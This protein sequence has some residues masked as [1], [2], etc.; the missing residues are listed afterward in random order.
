MPTFEVRGRD[1]TTGK[2][3]REVVEADD[4]TAAVK[5][6]PELSVTDVKKIGDGQS[7]KPSAGNEPL[8]YEEARANQHETP[9]VDPTFDPFEPEL[10]HVRYGWTTRRLGVIWVV[11]SLVAIVMACAGLEGSDTVDS[12]VLFLAALAS[13]IFGVL[14]L[15]A[16]ELR[17]IRMK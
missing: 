10:P 7:A 15:I 17:G 9:N 14:L 12:V 8:P 4:R 13:A 11:I 5:S 16:G 2:L 1:R 6:L 3:R